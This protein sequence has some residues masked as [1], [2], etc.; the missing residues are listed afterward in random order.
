MKPRASLPPAWPVGIAAVEAPPAACPWEVAPD[1][2][3]VLLPTGAPDAVSSAATRI[4][5]KPPLVAG[6]WLA[7]CST[8]AC[9]VTRGGIAA[10]VFGT[11]RAALRIASAAVCTLP[12]DIPLLRIASAAI[13]ICCGMACTVW[14][15]EGNAGASTSIV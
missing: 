11:T 4:S 2:A 10:G 5:A 15:A 9:S 8:G 3:L 6:N 14:T 7:T 12:E 13:V 1:S